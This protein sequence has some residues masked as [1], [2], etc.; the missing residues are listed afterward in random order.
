MSDVFVAYARST[1]KTA[2]AVAEALRGLGYTVWLDDDLP[3][4]RAYPHVLEEQLDLAK[5]ALVIWSA[6]A[7]KSDWVMSEANRARE[8][9]KLVQVI[10]DDTHLPMPFDQ[11][12]CAD[13]IGWSGEADAPGWRK[14][15]A[16]IADLAGGDPPAV[17]LPRPHSAATKAPLLAVLAFDNLSG[18]PEMAY[19][20]DGVSEEIRETVARGADLKVIGRASSF[21]F[22]GPDKAAAN[23]AAELGA[24]HILDGSVR[25]SG[26]RVRISTD[27]V[28]C[29][30]ATTVWS[31]RF[32]RE[33]TDIF[34]LQDEI[35][36][37]VAAALAL[38]FTPG[39]P[40]ETVDPAAYDRYLK[41]LRTSVGN[42]VDDATA[43]RLIQDMEEVTRLA[44]RF[45]R[46][47]AHLAGV[48]A[49]F[50]RYGRP[51]E[52][53]Q[54]MRARIIEA[55]ETAL[56]LDPGLGMAYQP[57]AEL[58]PFGHYSK[59]EA[60]LQ[61]AIS[62][63]PNDPQVLTI[64]AFFLAQVG[65]IREALSR[66]RQAFDL[67]PLQVLAAYA[68]ATFLDCDGRYGESRVLWD[69]FRVQWPE[70]GMVLRSAIAMAAYGRDWER[71]DRLIEGAESQLELTS[72]LLLLVRQ[73]RDPD[74][75]VTEG[76]AARARQELDETGAV[77]FDWLISL[78]NLGRADETFDL[79]DRASFDYMFD[80]AQH[81]VSGSRHGSI[82]FNLGAN[83]AMIRDARFPR[84]CAKL[85]LADYWLK[86]GRWPDCADHVP[87][88]FR[89]EV[90]RLARNPV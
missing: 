22:R 50:L 31:E 25:R 46:G 10:I 49:N 47:W 15:L 36:G 11:T 32:D 77:N 76:I 23:V 80:P 34:A 88:D 74:P 68:Y 48:R 45:A 17:A 81:W 51:S 90:A 40:G 69:A 52:P 24:T 27:L 65:R 54:V 20:S 58:E 86:T 66:S 16:S 79:V 64:N 44:P 53:Y 84:L 26:Q 85:G 14:A 73:L 6:D 5:A 83:D 60:L 41:V 71:V 3:A 37:A 59:R 7:A 18:D 8:A 4:H 62:V 29:A 72:G 35:A 9:R 30:S 39:K 56:S 70:S 78:Y 43:A 21:Q 19:F 13:L 87:Y 67:D 63:A 12:H 89:A 1:A 2:Q 38:V 42:V 75:R 33:L 55:A 61:R 28:Q 82:L 57:L